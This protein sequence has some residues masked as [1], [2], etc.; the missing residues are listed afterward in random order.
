MDTSPYFDLG[1]GRFRFWVTLDDGRPFG[2]TISK[3]TL[4]YRFHGQQDGSDALAIYRMNRQC[5]DAAVK[6][7]AGTGAREPVVLRDPDVSQPTSRTEA[8]ASPGV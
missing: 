7:R 4:H 6:R 2:A 8:P 1:T 5:I 3:E